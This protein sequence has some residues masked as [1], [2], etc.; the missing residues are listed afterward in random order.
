MHT[1]LTALAPPQIDEM[2][3]E[4][5][6]PAYEAFGKLAETRRSI[7]RYRKHN[8]PVPEYLT[9][10]LDAQQAAYDE[11]AKASAPF[12]AEYTRRGGWTRYL[13]VVSSSNGHVHR[14]PGY[15]GALTPGK[16]LVRP[17][18]ELSGNDDEGVVQ[19]CGHTACSKCFKD[20]P[21][22][23]K[24]VK[25]GMCSHEGSVYD[26]RDYGNPDAYASNRVYRTAKC[27]TCG[28]R[29]SVTSTGKLR[30]HKG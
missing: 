24:L 26:G 21:V 28:N 13:I 7:N 10:R 15:C 4:A 9:E 12:D 18:F 11:A 2:W 22:A 27:P 14:S 25:P 8:T 17:V 30:Q 6:G 5:M 1:D 19:S 3:A 20:A 23:G 16:T 29:A